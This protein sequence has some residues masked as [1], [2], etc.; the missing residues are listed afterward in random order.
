MATI[1]LSGYSYGTNT[2]GAD[3]FGVDVL[4]AVSTSSAIVSVAPVRVLVGSASIVASATVTALGGFIAGGDATV[5]SQSTAAS[6]LIRVRESTSQVD[7]T[8]TIAANG[9]GVFTSGAVSSATTV[10]T[11]VGEKFVLEE[12]G[13]FAYGTSVYGAGVYDYANFQTIV[14]ATSVNSTVSGFVIRGA[15]SAISATSDFVSGSN[16]A[17]VREGYA[18]PASVATAI[19]TGVFS[20]VGRAEIQAQST[21]SPQIVRIRLTNGATSLTSSV[22][23]YG[24]EKWEPILIVSETWTPLSSATD[25]WTKIAA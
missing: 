18:N 11:S 3:G 23:A 4:P 14:A 1:D 16:V 15:S 6:S 17:R 19:A 13:A 9:V 20:V 8:A 5:S 2:Y 25:T 7:S 12:S 21:V 10:I 22:S 24:R